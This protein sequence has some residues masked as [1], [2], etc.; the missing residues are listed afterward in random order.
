MYATRSMKFA[1]KNTS[2]IGL[3]YNFKIVNSA[4]GILDAGPFTIIPK[5]GVISPGC[6]E[7][8][9]VKFSPVEVD[10]DFTRI[11][12]ANIHH[13]NPS[14]EPLI[15]E[16]TGVAQRPII[17]FELP[18]GT[19]RERKMKDMSFVD[20]K[21]KII[22]FESLGTNIRNT[23]RFM[24]VNPTS[25][26][27]EFEW[28]EIPDETKKKNYFK[29]ATQKGLILSGKKSEMIFEYT[30]DAV[31]EHDSRWVFKIPSEKITQEFLVVGRVNEPNVLFESGKMKFGPLL[32]GGKA[33]ETVRIIN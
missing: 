25:S 32:L 11:F 33:K 7:N 27:Y 6:D 23:N 20:E 12:S 8:F 1:I 29:C 4:S 22:E 19:Y 18:V 17:H 31:G 15:I 5:T 16:A 28:E 14:Q 21:L 10:P 2:L 24:A 30:P 9:I 3:E 26:G 13:L